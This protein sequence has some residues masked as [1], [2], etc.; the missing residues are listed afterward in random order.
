MKLI[1]TQIVSYAFKREAPESLSG[2]CVSS[3]ALNE[4]LECHGSDL[5]RANYYLP[6]VTKFVDEADFSGHLRKYPF[7]K[8][9]TDQLVFDFGLDY[10]PV[11]HFGNL[12]LS[13]VA[14]QN[15]RDIFSA[16]ISR[17]PK[18]NRRRLMKR[19]TFAVETGIATIPLSRRAI[20]SSLDL[21]AAFLKSHQPKS[22]IRNTL[23]DVLILAAAEQE[24]ATL[25]TQDSL[26]NRFAAD[27]FGVT[28]KSQEE[29]VAVDFSRHEEASRINRESKRF[30]NKGWGFHERN[31]RNARA[32][33]I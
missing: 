23:Y 11:F 9:H 32:N 2:F 5:D 6:L 29:I 18:N 20:S 30:V 4:F 26:L 21:L 33:L 15:R 31:V 27:H 22:N 19:F 10:P 17:L 13:I 28:A 3:V 1:D 8:R 24:G 12:A 14:N 16:A 25:L 7:A